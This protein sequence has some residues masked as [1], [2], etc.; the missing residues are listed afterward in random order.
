MT[1]TCRD[2]DKPISNYSKTQRCR[3]CWARSDE[4]R[5][6]VSMAARLNWQK[7]EIRERYL[8]VARS[9]LADP[10][11]AAKRLEG[12]K[13]NR[14]WEKAS[15]AITPEHRAKAGIRQSA[16]KLAHIPRE[17]HEEY[18]Q[19]RRATRIGAEETARI[20]L[21]E[22]AKRMARFTRKLIGA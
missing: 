11:T 20:I 10:V 17:M 9:N 13:R 21:D 12:V 6:K 15:A 14:T 4:R 1:A 16:T 3:S 18:R 8:E 22:H 2:C 7:P 5:A 19:M